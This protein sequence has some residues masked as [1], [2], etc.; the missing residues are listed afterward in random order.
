MEELY[1]Q[2]VNRLSQLYTDVVCDNCHKYEQLQQALSLERLINHNQQE[3]TQNQN[4]LDS[5]NNQ[6]DSFELS[7]QKQNIQQRLN[8]TED[9]ILKNKKKFRSIIIHLID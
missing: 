4:T 6:P 2:E 1:Q 7:I 3:I 5:L 9:E 8:N